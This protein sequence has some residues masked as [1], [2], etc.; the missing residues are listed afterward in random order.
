MDRRQIIQA[1]AA[2]AGLAA[3]TGLRAQSGPA[4]KPGKPYA[5]Q[6]VNVLSVVAPQF[7]A[8]EAMLPEFEKLT[9]IQVKYQ[10]VPFASMREKLT[11][12]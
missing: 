9:G 2:A 6:T 5:G 4:L 8:H 11:A 1:A 7:S 3:T 10:Y 12:E